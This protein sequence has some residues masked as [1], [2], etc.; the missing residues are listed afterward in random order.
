MKKMLSFA[1]ALCASAALFAASYTN[2]TY[3][4]LA[5]EYA[6][7]AQTAFNA[8]Q[9]DDAV[10]YSKK[11][12]ENAALSKEYIDMMLSR[13]TVDEQMQRAAERIAWAESVGADRSFPD[14][15]AAATAA[16]GNAQ[17]AYA[18]E[19]FAAASEYAEQALAALDGVSADGNGTDG[20][21]TPP[22][23]AFYTVRSWVKTGDCYW[24]IAGLPYIYNNPRLWK[25]LYQANKDSMPQPG[26]PDLIL[27]GTKLKIPSLSGEVREGEYDPSK[28]YG[29]YNGGR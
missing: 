17:D 19:D 27:P 24:N 2:N 13:G 28:K 22:L 5:D 18:G 3:Q 4:K 8:G 26:D 1:V 21:G 25:H 7:K 12:A 11:A 14:E 15:Y 29:S 6:V 20:N 23:P 16:Y 10:E 9:Y